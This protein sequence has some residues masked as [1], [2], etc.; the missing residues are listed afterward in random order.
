MAFKAFDF[1]RLALASPEA[2]ITATRTCCGG[3]AAAD[4]VV[5]AGTVVVVL[6]ITLSLFVFDDEV[7]PPPRSTRRIPNTAASAPR[8]M[9]NVTKRRRIDQTTGGRPRPARRP[10]RQAMRRSRST[11][12]PTMA[13]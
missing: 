12:A 2:L 10:A 5:V 13:S 6:G 8:L 7:A 4:V 11:S 1:C 3:R 9:P